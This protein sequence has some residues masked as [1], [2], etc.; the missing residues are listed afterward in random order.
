[1]EKT[2]LDILLVQNDPRELY[3]ALKKINS[4]SN[5]NILFSNC[6][7]SV[8]VG[9]QFLNLQFDRAFYSNKLVLVRR[10]C[11]ID[12][13]DFKGVLDEWKI[14]YQEVV[15][16][17]SKFNYNSRKEIKNVYFPRGSESL[18]ESLEDSKRKGITS[19]NYYTEVKGLIALKY[20]LTNGD[21]ELLDARNTKGLIELDDK[22]IML[23]DQD[24]KRNIKVDKALRILKREGISI[25]ISEET[26]NII[27]EDKVKQYKKVGRIWNTR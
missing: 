23:V 14:K 19:C 20:Y 15:F 25:N 6:I 11:K 3:N 27:G 13:E 5:E 2:K 9:N 17:D 12:H 1:M 24:E 18:I 4:A 22:L 8:K 21:L 26:E 10:N 16:D 7:S